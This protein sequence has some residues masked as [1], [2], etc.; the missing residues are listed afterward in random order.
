MY[1][2]E[3]KEQAILKVLPRGDKTIQEIANALNVNLLTL[4]RMAT[5]I[6]INYD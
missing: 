3:F 4:K 2:P 5:K 6:T 1:T